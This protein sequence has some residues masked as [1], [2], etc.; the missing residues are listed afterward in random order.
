MFVM[1]YDEVQAKKIFPNFKK[2]ALTRLEEVLGD[3]PSR[4][5][6][7]TKF[8]DEGL[9]DLKI[10]ILIGHKE[11]DV[12]NALKYCEIKGKQDRSKV[13]LLPPLIPPV[14]PPIVVDIRPTVS[15]DPYSLIRWVKL[16]DG[17]EG[18]FFRPALFA[19]WTGKEL[20]Q[21]CAFFAGF[22]YRLMEGLNHDLTYDQ[23][24]AALLVYCRKTVVEI[25]NVVGRTV[26]GEQPKY[27]IPKID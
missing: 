10:A 13:L 6:L 2:R 12:Q 15:V 26:K 24:L 17:E 7:R 21:I 25:Q 20:I 4:E 5:W 11:G 9:N 1:D 19:G 16:E 3:I 27:R 23:Q 14:V 8:H 22:D 18:V